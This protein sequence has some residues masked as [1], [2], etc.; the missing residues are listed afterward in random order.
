VNRWLL[1][2][3]VRVA[4]E[5]YVSRRWDAN[6]RAQY[7]LRP[8]T[9]WPLSVDRLVWPSVFYPANF[10]GSDWE[11]YSTI[12]VDPAIEGTD[13]WLDLA[14]MRTHY[15]LHRALAPGGAFVAIELL[16]EKEADGPS[17]LYTIAGDI[18][19]GVWLD[20]TIPDRPPDGSRLLGYDVADAGRISGLTNCEYTKEETRDLP[21]V[22]AS[23]LNSFGLFAA[24]EDAVTFRQ[25]CDERIPEHAP[26]WVYA[27]WRLPIG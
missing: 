20:P 2:F 25:R 23:R 27:L 5:R 19:Y 6:A 8:D 14:R 24:L 7:L 10:K 22:W 4:K 11:S 26:F 12:E 21:P 15:E 18:Q 16:S 1:R 3:D 17:I 9:E 13:Y